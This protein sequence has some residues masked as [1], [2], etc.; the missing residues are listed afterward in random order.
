M[1]HGSVYENDALGSK[2]SFDK[3]TGTMLRDFYNTW[4]APNN[5]ILVVAG[6]V[7]PQKTLAQIKSLF[8][9]IP[10]K[11]IP[12]RPAIHLQPVSSETMRLDTDLPY[13]LAVLSYRVPGS[14]SPDYAA[15]R[16]LSD[17][18]SSQ[19][20]TLYDLVVQGKALDAGFSANLLPA[21]GIAFALAAFPEGANGDT[22]IQQINQIIADDL[23][24]G[25]PPDLVEASKR[26]ARTTAELQKNSIA[27]LA[28][29]WSNAVAV[30][31]RNSP[32]DDIAAI[33]KVT[34]D[35]VNEVARKY[36][37]RDEALTAVLTPRPS[38]KPLS[39]K[40]FGA[41]EALAGS[42]SGPVTLPSWAGQALSR[43]VIPK[44]TTNPI[45]STLPNGLR[46]IAQPETISNTVTVIGHVKNNPD[47]QTPPKQEGVGSVLAGLFP[48]GTQT[49]DRVAFQKAL[50]DIGA[51]ESAGTDFS[52]A[53]LADHFERG[54]ALLA[55][56]ILHPALPTNG[57]TT[58]RQQTGQA[59]AGQLQSPDYLAG[60]AL[61]AGLFP[62]NDPTLRE[63]TP[64]T[65]STLTLSNVKDY[66]QRVFRPDLTTIVVIGNVSAERAEAVIEEYFG[67]WKASGAQPET[68]LPPVP[69]NAPGFTAVPDDSR[70]QVKTDLAET[71]GLNR[72]N[73][74]Y[75]ALEVGNHVLGGGF[76]ATRLYRD[77]RESSGLVYFVSSSFDIGKTRGIYRVSF[78]C[79]PQKVSKARS[80]VV[81]DLREMQSSPVSADELQQ[82]KAMLLRQVPLSESS[83][84]S[85]TGGWLA[86]STIGLPLD[87][88]TIAAHHYVAL[89]ADQ[90]R[91]AF[92]K[93]LRPDDLFEVTQG[94]NPQ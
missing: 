62:K 58:V 3:T 44:L 90:V 50:D 52:L 8:G 32:D 51:H 36:L 81:R 47:L 83:V 75:Y 13:G 93:W 22:L 66:Y 78:G 28:M 80:I 16:V 10:E 6:D 12:P 49:L 69:S 23:K 18:L 37:R 76:Y 67:E 63:A 39:S 84:D 20:G 86:R 48:Y 88:P 92:R 60:R 11:K 53:V 19:R 59:V 2:L 24:N 38:G 82:A 65:V 1:F 30:E 68:D 77:L 7:E 31:G 42:P 46:V 74:D 64:Q 94:P 45:V 25:V 91:A 43:L 79:D 41:P 87:E 57:F 85:L 40:S 4:Y 73:P 5:A 56:N 89:T 21:A 35:Q 27:G 54:A 55:D 15:L 34:V 29:A 26:Q 61:A 17:V 71:L 9:D 70:V 33:Q 14:D 72:F